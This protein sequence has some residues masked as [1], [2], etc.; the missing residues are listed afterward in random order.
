MPF[1]W[2]NLNDMPWL[3]DFPSVGDSLA[4]GAQAGAPV[5]QSRANFA[6]LAQ[7]QRQ[8]DATMPLKMQEVALQNQRMQTEIA[9]KMLENQTRAD[10]ASDKVILDAYV[11]ALNKGVTP[12]QPTFR[13]T[14]MYSV[15]DGIRTDHAT[16]KKMADENTAFKDKVNKLDG[17]GM[18]AMFDV[19]KNRRGPIPSPAE[20]A[21]LTK[22]EERIKLAGVKA[23]QD[24]KTFEQGLKT[25][26]PNVSGLDEEGRKTAIDLFQRLNTEPSVKKFH[27]A[28]SSHESM[29]NQV[30]ESRKNP[31]GAN[32][33]SIIFSFMK[34]I[35]PESTVREGEQATAQQSG[36]I[37][38]NIVA[39]YNQILRGERLTQEQ[40][41][42]FLKASERNV[43]A[44]AK[45]ANEVRGRYVKQGGNFGIGEKFISESPY[46]FAKESPSAGTQ[47]QS[48]SDVEAAL[49]SGAVK[50]GD[51]ISIYDPTTATYKKKRVEK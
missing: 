44:Y 15:L 1:D 21:E 32:D 30:V 42:N 41:E 2:N 7:E 24:M 5:A 16:Y 36:G 45:S 49:K 26:A 27:S 48:V 17:F 12:E 23:E 34:S 33:I 43:E 8:F 14:S 37:P 19:G 40:R 50:F 3:T 51:E 47:F 22:Q 25:P 13:N 6:R 10:L 4:K 28:L 11:S 29:R 39:K 31:T 18:S 35:D 46:S 38:E 20:Y 9:G